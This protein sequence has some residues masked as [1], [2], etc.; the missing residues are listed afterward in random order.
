MNIYIHSPM[1][2]QH[3]RRFLRGLFAHSREQTPI[4]SV[5]WGSGINPVVLK[6]LESKDGLICFGVNVRDKPILEGLGLP[7][8][9]F[10]SISL[11]WPGVASVTPDNQAVGRLAAEYFLDRLHR[12]FLFVGTESH[13]Y[14]RER[15][16]GFRRRLTGLEVWVADDYLAGGEPDSGILSMLRQLPRPL[17]VFAANDLF[18]RRVCRLAV[19]AGISVPEEVA[20]LGVDREELVSLSCPVPLSS[21][22]VDSENMGRRAAEVLHCIVRGTLPP[23]HTEVFP[24]FGVV[25]DLST[26]TLA[27]GDEGL[28]KA[29]C[30]I[31][32]HAFEKIGV[33]DVARRA[34]VG[35]RT[36][37]RKFS[38]LVGKSID[39]SIRQTRLDRARIL[40]RDSKLTLAEIAERCGFSSTDYFSKVFKAQSGHTPA[41][42]RQR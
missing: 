3:E 23:N 24:P 22:D 36:L 35:R 32:D 9:N 6:D 18:A 29:L 38:D 20:I 4:W 19:E 12:N 16:V 33:E 30:F 42:F 1:T 40:L 39:Q 5:R 15:L 10:S 34:G 14:S 28:A 2:S 8:V 7:I 11:P 26:D 17:A 21:V 13:S 25:T 31:R 37:E 27:T 41:A